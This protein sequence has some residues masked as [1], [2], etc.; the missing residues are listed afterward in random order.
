MQ[1]PVPS[2]QED[3]QAQGVVCKTREVVEDGGLTELPLSDFVINAAVKP[4]KPLTPAQERVANLIA[5]GWGYKQV[6][7]RL[8]TS[9]RTVEHHVEAIAGLLPDDD[10]SPRERVRI[11][12]LCVAIKLLVHEAA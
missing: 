7:Q 5:R 11:W 10:L 8:R 4:F 1:R 2:G 12:A 3:A 6:A 9:P